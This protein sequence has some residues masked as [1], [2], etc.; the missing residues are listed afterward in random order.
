[1]SLSTWYERYGACSKQLVS[2]TAFSKEQISWKRYAQSILFSIPLPIL[3][4]FSAIR[5]LEIIHVYYFE[6]IYRVTYPKEFL[7]FLTGSF[8]TDDLLIILLGTSTFCILFFS[9]DFKKKKPIW[10]VIPIIFATLGIAAVMPLNSAVLADALALSAFPLIA[11]FYFLQRQKTPDVFTPIKRRITKDSLVA[12][13]AITFLA[14]SILSLG[15]WILYPLAPSKI[16]SSLNWYG[17]DTE[18]QLFYAFGLLST[19]LSVLLAFSFGIRPGLHGIQEVWRQRIPKTQTLAIDASPI[20]LRRRTI[21]LFL[22]LSSILVTLFSIY[23]YV[24]TINP[25]FQNLSVDAPYYINQINAIQSNGLFAENGPFGV[26]NERALSI[27]I[28][29][30][31]TTITGQ[32]A[33]SIVPFLP[34]FLGLTLVFSTYYLVRYAIGPH[35]IATVIAPLFTAFSFQFIAG[36]YGGFFSNM[37]ALPFFFA[38]ILF[39]IRYADGVGKKW[40][41]IAIFVAALTMILLT[42]VYTWVFAVAAFS[43]AIGI[44]LF[45]HQPDSNL[46]TEIKRYLPIMIIIIST[47]LILLAI[48]S[49]VRG[50]SGLDFL[51]NL[52]GSSISDDYFAKRWFNINYM[53]RSYIGGFLT[54]SAMIALAL[55]WAIKADYRNRFNVVILSSM[56]L[57]SFFFLFGDTVAQSRIFYNIPL[58]IPAAIVVANIINGSYLSSFSYQSRMLIAIMIILHMANYALRSLAN[59]YLQIP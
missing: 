2:S 23:P 49:M 15:N 46:K 25:D 10:L 31:L 36:I 22:V 7:V 47:A 43:I 55:I 30:G 51:S 32:P 53:F 13:T 26:A 8:S 52:A 11:G 39:F 56:F 44:S 4:L 21:Y 3:A 5:A 1:M 58:Q 42:H 45:K 17:A 14:F 34:I 12:S 27:L 29:Y 19:V 18:A 59:F 38:A 48:A 35:S 37:L 54:N 41:N 28:F 6:T 9:M 57:V 50:T 20:N 33:S 40:V 16:Y 24:P